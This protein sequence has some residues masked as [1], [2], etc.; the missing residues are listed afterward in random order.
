W[1]GKPVEMRKFAHRA[2]IDFVGLEMPPA[3]AVR[4]EY[5]G[6]DG[7]KIKAAPLSDQD[8]RTLTR[9]IDL[10]CPIDL[11]FDLEHP[12]RRGYGFACD[13][14]RPTLTLTHPAAGRNAGLT[15]LLVGMHDYYSGLDRKSFRVVADFALDGAP[16]GTDLGD[17]FGRKATGVW[18]LRL[19]KPVRR[20]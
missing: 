12:E 3:K 5:V 15:R 6:P 7:R 17:R 14:T 2:D 16:A 1:K 9:W 13:D 11:D 20:L 8:R 19:K 10:G 18:E 4:G